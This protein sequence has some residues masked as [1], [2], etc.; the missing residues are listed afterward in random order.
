MD[1]MQKSGYY[2]HPRFLLT[3]KRFENCEMGERH[4][5]AGY[6]DLTPNSAGLPFIWAEQGAYCSND[7]YN[8]IIPQ[9]LFSL[10]Q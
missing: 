2:D 8:I 4:Y 1:D 3:A 9:Y 6:Y 5:A 7:G 10:K